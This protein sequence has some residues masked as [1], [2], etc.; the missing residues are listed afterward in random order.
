MRPAS[1]NYT[2]HSGTITSNATS[3]ELSGANTE[4][5]YF[6]FLN[7]SDTE[8]WL[9]IGTPAVASQPSI[10]VVAGGFWEPLVAPK[11]SV[12]VICATS[13]KAFTCKE[14]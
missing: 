12:N 7:V 4:R 14:A 8:M 6:F 5:L 2:D 10:R 11:Q 9:G 1:A 3:Q 13:T